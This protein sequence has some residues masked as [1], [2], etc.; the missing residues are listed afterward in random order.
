MFIN[1]NFLYWGIF[2]ILKF[3]FKFLYFIDIFSIK[4]FDQSFFRIISI[5]NFQEGHIYLHFRQ[6]IGRGRRRQSGSTHRF[7]WWWLTDYFPKHTFVSIFWIKI[8]GKVFWELILDD[9]DVLLEL[10]PTYGQKKVLK[11][12]VTFKYIKS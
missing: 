2:V 10:D 12:L 1:N 8:I 9:L 5:R 7:H 4:V 11:R 3:I 6:S